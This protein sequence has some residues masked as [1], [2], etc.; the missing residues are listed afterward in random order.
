MAE[1]VDLL[2]VRATPDNVFSHALPPFRLP[3]SYEL[4]VEEPRDLGDAECEDDCPTETC[5][6]SILS[7]LTSWNLQEVDGCPRSGFDKPIVRRKNQAPIQSVMFDGPMRLPSR[8]PSVKTYKSLFSGSIIE[9]RVEPPKEESAK[10]VFPISLHPDF[11]RPNPHQLSQIPVACVRPSSSRSL[12][13]VFSTVTFVVSKAEA[14]VET[15]VVEADDVE[16]EPEPDLADWA[17]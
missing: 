5:T 13:S 11:P 17:C 7:Q 1:P 10:P 9:R 15:E 14:V 16:P 2:V 12:M 6:P 8:D 4:D 3:P